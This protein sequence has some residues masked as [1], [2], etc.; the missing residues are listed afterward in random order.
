VKKVV[1]FILAILV[2]NNLLAN[3][4][5]ENELKS[6]AK[7]GDAKS[8]YKLGL[9]YQ[10]TKDDNMRA[11]IWYKKAA[12]QG[13]KDAMLALCLF[14]EVISLGDD[15]HPF[16]SETN[17]VEITTNSIRLTDVQ[18]TEHFKFISLKANSGDPIAQYQLGLIYENGYGI[19]RNSKEALK[20]YKLALK[21]GY[22]EAN[23]AY[24]LLKEAL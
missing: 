3:S 14:K 19:K 24:E 1:F 8:Q 6:G 9:Y 7:R 21:H 16:K 18:K 23:L 17:N 20:W 11:M 22:K 2:T 12:K 5:Y 10:T 13:N 15:S 4:V